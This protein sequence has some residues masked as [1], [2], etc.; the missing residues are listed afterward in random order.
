MREGY[1]NYEI[2]DFENE[3]NS[4]MAFI[5]NLMIQCSAELQGML[6]KFNECK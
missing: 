1:F 4:I 5:K 2:D 3:L 6:Q